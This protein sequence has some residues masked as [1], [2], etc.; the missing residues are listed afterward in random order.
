MS[1]GAMLLPVDPYA[2][3]RRVL[4]VLGRPDRVRQDISGNR[5]NAANSGSRN[6]NF[7]NVPW[8]SNWNISIRAASGNCRTVVMQAAHYGTLV[9][10]FYLLRQIHLGVRGTTSTKSGKS[11]RHLFMGKKYKNLFQQIVAPEN[12]R[13]A[14]Y[15][16]SKGKRSTRSYK[17]FTRNLN[18]RLSGTRRS[19]LSR[20]Y[21]QGRPRE[22]LVYEP[23][24]RLIS[25][26]PFRDRV[27]QHAVNNVIEP[28]FDD[29]FLPQ[30]YA[31]RKGKGTHAAARDVQAELR[32]MHNDGHK[33]WVLKTDFS[34]YF[35]SI[36]RSIL[37][38]EFRRKI[39]CPPTLGLLEKL[40]PAQGV[41]IR[42]GELMSQLSANLYGH[43]VDRWLVH[44]KGVT[45]FFRYMD[46]II[47]LGSNRLA[48][49]QLRKDL[50]AFAVTLGLS[51]SHWCIQPAARGINFVGYRIWRTHKLLRRDSVI[52]AKRKIKRYTKHAEA[53][54]LRM[55]LASWR[56]HAQWADSHN[57]LK[58]LGVA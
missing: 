41:G 57:L 13:L 22:F 20:R 53:D 43:I 10:L 34:K 11:G 35:H 23:K 19:L 50:Q 17:E 18:G 31:C 46:D 25:A 32:R 56:G 45:K 15:K 3:L 47:V 49:S 44:T 51:F 27:V 24:K 26:L 36:V 48:L 30:S 1:Q 39:S 40:I 5:T 4:V 38:T 6:S 28:I 16:T 14:H 33:T 21:R 55:F 7:N 42:I 37:H 12:L 58:N 9:S 52:R 2:A 8:N 54:R 29:I